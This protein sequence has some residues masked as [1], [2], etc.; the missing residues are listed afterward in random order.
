MHF[1]PQTWFIGEVGSDTGG[2]TRELWR[3]LGIDVMCLC[4]GQPN[5]LVLRHDSDRVVVG[6]CVY[7][8]YFDLQFKLVSITTVL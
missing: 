4:E 8:V 6:V 1:I 3:L 7:A 5:M 2:L